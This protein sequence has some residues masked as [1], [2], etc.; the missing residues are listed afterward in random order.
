MKRLAAVAVL[1]IA[2]MMG[3]VV[4]LAAAVASQT[5]PDT[6][7]DTALAEIPPDL[8]GVYMGAARTCPGLPWQVLAAIGAV[9]SHHAQGRAD[10]ATGNVRP[11]ILGPPLDGTRGFARIPDPTMPDGWAHALGPMQFLSTTWAA[12]GRVA[13][14]RPAGVAPDPHNAWDAIYTAAAYLCGPAGR[15]ADLD[16][17][18]LRYNHSQTYLHQVLAKAA[19]YTRA[20]ATPNNSASAGAPTVG[21]YTLPVARAVFDAHPDYLTKAHHDYPA[22]DIPVPTGTPVYAATAGR[23]TSVGG[24][25]G[26]GIEIA[27]G[28]GYHYIYCH[29]LQRLVADGA[30]V[31]SGQQIMLSDNTGNSTGP[32]LHFGIRSPTG[33]DLCPQP[34][35]VAWY[36]G[37][38]ATPDQAGTTGCSY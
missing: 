9:E 5:S 31:A 4:I 13:P 10:P 24:K 21:N 29:G 6:P 26:T 37:Q 1:A 15:I 25:C 19:E 12:W 14:G 23:V 3:L 28:D 22:A 16:A 20:T 17:A 36:D 11:P 38:A 27:A 33:T 32:H 35:L 7:S 18:V 2:G 34:L 8:L 30:L